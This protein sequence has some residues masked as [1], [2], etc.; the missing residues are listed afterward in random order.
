MTDELMK[1][2]DILRYE[3]GKYENKVRTVHVAIN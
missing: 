1:I 2:K 3:N